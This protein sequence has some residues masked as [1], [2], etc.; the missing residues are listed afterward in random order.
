MSD[1]YKNSTVDSIGLAIKRFEERVKIG[2]KE[3]RKKV[4]EH[5]L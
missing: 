2:V 5:D 3:I 4:E 1:F